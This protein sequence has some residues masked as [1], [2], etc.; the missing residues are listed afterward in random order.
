MASLYGVNATKLLVNNPPELSGV[1]EAG[2]RMRVIYDTYTLVAD[3]A[4]ADVIYMGSLIPKGA[5]VMQVMVKAADLDGSGG[6]VDIGWAA[7][8]DAVE[9]ADASGFFA[10][11]DVATAA[12][13]FSSS[14]N[15]AAPAGIHKKFAAACQ[16]I[17]TFDGDCDA[18]T[19]AISIAIWYILD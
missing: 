11:V 5:R 16:P 15:A 14:E 9:A 8:A 4:S 19:G 6:T 7:S 1:G 17:I 13:V 2:G 3:T 18:T 12:D 10:N